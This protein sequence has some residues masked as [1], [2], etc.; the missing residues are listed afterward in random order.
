MLRRVVETVAVE[1][2]LAFAAIET[3][4][5]DGLLRPT[6]VSGDRDPGILEEQFPLR[7][8]GADLGRLVVKANQETPLRESDRRLLS[9]IAANAATA[10]Q[11]ART[12]EELRRSREALIGAH[13][14]ERRR[15]GRELHDGLGPTIASLHLRVDTAISLLSPDSERS[16]ALLSGTRAELV[17]M[18]GEI[19]RIVTGLRPPGLDEVGLVAAVSNAI[20]TDAPDEIPSVRVDA[21]DLPP[22]PAEVEFAA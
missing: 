13:E 14:S 6:V 20:G 11:V 21:D 22:L 7:F 9:N 4:G 1:L 3:R 10:V 16:A 19:R 8:A 15:L 18:I 5:D 17:S 2:K 12:T